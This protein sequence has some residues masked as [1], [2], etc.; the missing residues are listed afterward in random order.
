[1]KEENATGI[2]RYI[3]HLYCLAVQDG[4]YIDVVECSPLDRKVLGSILGRDNR[5]FKS[6]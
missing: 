1:M 6:P 4:F 2:G 3:I 5:I